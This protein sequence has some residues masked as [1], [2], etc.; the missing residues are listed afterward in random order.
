MIGNNE[1]IISSETVFTGRIFNLRV[2]EVLLPTGEKKKR[3]IVEHSGSVAA[4][5]YTKEGNFILIRQYR[6]PIKKTIWEI[7]AGRLKAGES[8]RDALLREMKEE[9][10]A[11][12]GKLVKLAEY[13]SSPGF[14]DEKL[15]IY[16]YQDFKLGEARPEAGEDITVYQV[17]TSEALKMIERG[18]IK[19]AKSIIGILLALRE[20]GELRRV[21]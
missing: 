6:S 20:L 18:E 16:L 5:P 17:S 14:T 10:G 19:D 15:H 21:N 7:P 11:S 9:I 2:D 3:E 8:A 1:K 4:V 12:G 13:F